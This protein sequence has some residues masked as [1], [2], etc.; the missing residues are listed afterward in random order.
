MSADY[1]NFG[2]ECG[3]F[4]RGAGPGGA[5]ERTLR[6]AAMRRSMIDISGE[7]FEVLEAGERGAPLLLML[8]GFPEHAGA[9]AAMAARLAPEF[10]CVAP[11]QR[12]YGRSPRPAEAEAYRTGLLVKDALGV[13]AHFSPEAPARAVIGHDWGASVAYALAMAAP[14]R[15]QALVIGNGVHPIP[16]QRE[17]A[18]GGAQSEA[19]Q[20]ID[21]LRMPKS[22]DRL[23]END[24]ALLKGM[25]AGFGEAEPAWM[26]EDAWQ[27]YREAWSQPGSVR[28][29]VNWYRAT[30]IKVAK[31]GAPIPAEALPRLDAE[32]MRVT[33][34]HLLLW[35]LKDGALLPGCRDGLDA[36]CDDLTV[37]E[38]ADCDHWLFHQRPDD[39]AAEIRSFLSQV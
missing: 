34:P 29:M 8:H 26:T 11:N 39:L 28:G 27:G 9:W 35:G 15:M 20:Y 10:H 4:T 6:E 30:P 22:Q 37:R 36:L 2:H 32:K 7:T 13:L 23:A 1:A 19:S 24:F 21:R 5:G 16:F 38:F 3:V 12:G 17:L 14:E 18:K 25:I 33:P 31:P